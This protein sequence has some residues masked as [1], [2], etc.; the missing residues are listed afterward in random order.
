MREEID[1]MARENATW[2]AKKGLLARTVTIKVRYDDFTTIT[3]SQS[4][5]PTNDPDAIARRAVELLKKTD[6]GKRPVRLLGAGVHNLGEPETA[7][8][9]ETEDGKLPFD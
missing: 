9:T 7:T 8:D 5:A 3:R 6:A 4:D 2:L 1:D